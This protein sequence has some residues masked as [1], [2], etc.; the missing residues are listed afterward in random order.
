[1][2]ILFVVEHF[3][4][5]IGGAEKLFFELAKTLATKGHQ[6][7]VV[8]TQHE[9]QLALD[10][11][12]EGINIKRIPCRNRFLFTF[13]SLSTILRIAK[14]CDVLHTTT[15]NAALP[16]WLAGKLKGK[17]VIITFHEVWG[18]LWWRLPYLNFFQKLIY[19]TYEQLILKLSFYKYVAVSDFTKKALADSGISA[20]RIS[21]IYNGLEYS[22]FE[23]YIHKAPKQFTYTFFGRLGV[24]K[25]LD[26]L[27]PAAKAFSDLYPNSRLKLILPK[28]PKALFKKVKSIIQELELENHVQFLHE[29]SKE[30][31]YTEIINS[32][33]VVI[34]SYSEGFCFAAAETMALGVPIISSQRGALAE[35]VS[36]KYLSFDVFNTKGLID[37][38]QIARKKEWQ[39]IPKRIFPLHDMVREYLNLYSKERLDG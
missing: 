17:R 11:K 30:E 23:G 39:E 28:Q 18:N 16:A 26:L 34:P 27:L 4:P 8:T 7:W 5:Y 29:L 19:Y 13:L 25:G 36:G 9:E 21:R 6:I 24:S 2:K 12:I 37:T 22:E 3:Y 14:D 35:V 33:C 10:E 15:Y 20:N 31:L 38:L 1:M 32:S